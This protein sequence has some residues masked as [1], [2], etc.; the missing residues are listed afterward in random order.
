MSLDGFYQAGLYFSAGIVFV[1]QDTEFRV[2]P[3]LVKVEFSLLILVEVH[4]PFHQ[5][6]DLRGSFTHHFS[7]GCGIVYPVAR[8][9][10]V[11]N[12][13]FKIIH[14]QVGNG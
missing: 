4:S 14:F 11:L 10:C 7:H 12:V 9:H 1:V 5:F 6:L 2:S 3:L 13:L 8:Y